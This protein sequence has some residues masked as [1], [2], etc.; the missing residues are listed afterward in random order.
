MSGYAGGILRINLSTEQFTMEDIPE[1]TISDFI[2]GRGFAIKIL[3]DEVKCVDA[4]SDKNK[5]VLATGPLTGLPIPGSGKMV[6]ASKS[7][8]TGGYGDGNIGT[9]AAIYMKKAGY[10][11]IIIEGKAIKP[12]YLLIEDD[13]VK[14]LS[15]KGIWGKNTFE[16]Q[17]LLEEKHGKKCGTLLIGRAGENLIPY[18]VVMSQKGRAGG[19]PGMGAVLGAKNI[20]AIVFKGYHDIP[21]FDEE[22]LDILYKDANRTI[23]KNPNYNDWLQQGTMA[24]IDWANGLE[25]LPTNNFRHGTF[26]N[27][28]QCDGNVVVREKIGRKG[29]PNCIMKCGM[30]I[31]DNR[32]KRVEIDYE[33]VAML[34]P[35]LGIADLKKIGVLNRL[36]DEYG[37][38]TISLGNSIGFLMEASEKKIIDTELRWGDFDACEML[39]HEI[40]ERK[41][42]GRLICDGVK[43]ASKKFG[44]GSE[45][46][47][48]H[49]K[50]LEVSAYTCYG[51]P[52]MALCFGTSPIGGAHKDGLTIDW[53][54]EYSHRSYGKEAAEEVIRQ[55]RIRSGFYETA[56]VCRFQETQGGIDLDRYCDLFETVTG[57]TLNINKIKEVGDR[58][59]NLIR[60]FWARDN[61]NWDRHMDYPPWRWFEGALSNGRFKERKI[62]KKKYDKLLS[63]YYDLRGWNNRGI[64]K[65]ETLDA[66][67]LS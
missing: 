56:I 27:S 24:G 31:E 22:K 67:N 64:P 2:G 42:L 62:D 7:P 49:V 34:G 6:I 36:A 51:Y 32:Q 66:L 23:R 40:V 3:W 21:V 13:R 5:I 1:R 16:A 50:G 47:A 9:R 33:N 45:I 17:D 61:E 48:M 8:L 18:A 59:F 26:S 58:I 4:F 29:C 19:R 30:I 60:C 39:I 52:T 14:I 55:Q 25:C 35:N 54:A 38:D 11:V 10:D 20:K 37:I 63:S 15:A 44:K 41:G 46:W 43:K 65:K 12:S 53:E 28:N 57:R